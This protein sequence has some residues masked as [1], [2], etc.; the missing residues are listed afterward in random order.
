[1]KA[2]ETNNHFKLELTDE[3]LSFLRKN[4][5]PNFYDCIRTSQFSDPVTGKHYQL[6]SAD[7]DN[8]RILLGYSRDV[9]KVFEK[10][11][12]GVEDLDN[13]LGKLLIQEEEKTLEINL[14]WLGAQRVLNGRFDSIGCSESKYKFTIKKEDEL[15]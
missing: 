4:P 11:E 3:E 13:G 10:K 15:D 9:D 6:F 12:R 1:M 5:L 7:A 2:Q 8:Y 14:S